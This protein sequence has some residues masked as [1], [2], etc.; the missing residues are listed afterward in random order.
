VPRKRHM[1]FDVQG[2]PVHEE[3]FGRDGLGGPSSLLYHRLLPEAAEDI[4]EGPEDDVSLESETIHHHAH[5]QAF[6]LQ[7]H[8]DAATG[9]QWLLANEDIR[10]GLLAPQQQQ[11]QLF[12]DASADEILFVH[13]GSG[14]LHTQ[15]GRLAFRAHDYLV[16]PR[17]TAYQ[18]ELDRIEEARIL[19][20]EIAGA[21]D[22]PAAYR[23]T[24]GQLT[25]LAPYSER[26]FRGPE[27]LEDGG[28]PTQLWVKHAG[29]I[30]IYALNHHPFDLVGWDGTL[31]PVAFNI[32]D[33]EARTALSPFP[34]AAHETFVAP[35]VTVGSIVPAPV[36][37]DADVQPHRTDLDSDHAVY[38][39]DGEAEGSAGVRAGSLLHHVG[40]L[41]HGPHPGTAARAGDEVSVTVVTSR[42]LHRTQIARQ[43]TDPGYPFS[44]RAAATPPAALRR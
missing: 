1:R 8:G 2:Q 34:R 16:V 25:E 4:T 18:M 27:A 30:S 33:F 44:W 21:V 5:L 42:P 10:L 19:I 35:G 39:V 36:G 38:R 32:H 40:G 37:S 41:P 26:D 43:V 24:S 29:R 23:S 14:T 9:R 7:A 6:R 15:F 31:Y 12:T 28:G 13:Q 20:M 17:G 22:C 3:L 11:Q